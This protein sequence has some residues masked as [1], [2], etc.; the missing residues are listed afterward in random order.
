MKKKILQ[1]SIGLALSVL[2][3]YLAVKDI[4]WQDIFSTLQQDKDWWYLVPASAL[5]MASFIFRAWRWHYFLQPVKSLRFHPLFS[6]IMVGYMGNNVLPIRL[7]EILRAYA[8]N[9]SSNV[10]KSAGLATVVV[11]RLVDTIGLLVFF[12]IA[13]LFASL[14]SQYQSVITLTSILAIGL[15]VFLIGITFF[16][17]FTK[18]ILNRIFGLLPEFV[19]EKLQSITDAFLDGLAGLRQ[20][21]NY[22]KILAHTLIIWSLFAA[23]TFYMLKAFR[24]DTVYSMTFVSGIVVFLIGTVGV[25][26]PSSPGYV[27]TFHYAIVQALALFGV[28]N[29][30]ALGFAIVIHLMN[31]LPVTGLGLFYFLREGLRFQDVSKAAEGTKP[32]NV[33]DVYSP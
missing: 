1:I 3:A 23:S 8:L 33:S 12:L 11:E 5:F 14:P 19:S 27:G 30:P 4:K 29:E 31:Y 22:W 18:K 28:P 7:G 16:E 13:V 15:L 2:F 24:F 17:A 9:R 32:T 10:S 21:Q 26:I 6:A 20:T 25:M